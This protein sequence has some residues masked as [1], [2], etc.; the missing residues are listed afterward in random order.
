[1]PVDDEQQV[2]KEKALQLLRNEREL[3]ALRVRHEQTV[4]WLRI[5]QSIPQLIDHE[6]PQAELC[7]R[8]GKSLIT[9]LRVQRA[10]F[11]AYRGGE[12]RLVSGKGAPEQAALGREAQELVERAP[13]GLCNEPSDAGSMELAS[14]TGLHRFLFTRINAESG[15][16]LLLATG[17]DSERAQFQAPFDEAH[18]TQLASL[19]QH[20]EILLRNARLVSELERDKERLQRFNET[21]EQK[22]LERTAELARKNRDMRLVLDNV[23]HGFITLSPEGRMATERSL[24]VDTW[25]GAGRELLLLWDYFAPLSESFAT[26]V[27]LGWEQ[28]ADGFMPLDASLAQLPA[29]LVTANRTFTFR[30]SP[31]FRDAQLEGVLVIVSDVTGQLARERE[32][33]EQR[34]LMQSFKQLTLDRA[35]FFEFMRETTTMMETVAAAAAAGDRRALLR[36]IH[37]LKGNS[38]TVGLSRIAR[39]CHAIEEGL[40]DEDELPTRELVAELDQRWKAI[41]EHVGQLVGPTRERMIEVSESS[42]AALVRTLADP[43]RAGHA[44][45]HLLALRLEP[46][47]RVFER[48]AEQAT[49]LA[50]RKGLELEVRLETAGLRVDPER[51]SPL[52]SELTHLVRNAVAHGFQSKAERTAQGKLPQNRLSLLADVGA[53]ELILEIADDGRGIDWQAL[54][55][56]AR[57]RGLAAETRLELVQ[58]LFADGITTRADADEISGRGVGMSVVK[59]R[60]DS[61]NGRIQLKSEPG[62]GTTWFVSLPILDPKEV[63]RG[64]QLAYSKPPER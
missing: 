39:L 56:R 28:L 59:S 36:T 54:K 8:L 50:H 32:E 24:I 35:G 4:S 61:M 64:E 44:L 13:A 57:E 58:A 45:D 25:F 31:F 2:L 9:G 41:A 14:A 43:A 26:Q 22:V 52:L 30:Y 5:L 53:G 48:L 21:L 1:M 38:A 19:G 60:V 46:L 37:T 55:N 42:Y 51:F 10:N 3:F 40:K 18:A 27:R 16:S 23:D 11:F 7:K 62:L 17:Y 29:R 33:A 6:L 49:T 63:R 20:I 47:S 34:E 12:L 15:E